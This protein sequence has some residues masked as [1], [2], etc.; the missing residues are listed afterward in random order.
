MLESDTVSFTW[1][2]T[3]LWQEFCPFLQRKCTFARTNENLMRLVLFR[4]SFTMWFMSF[5][6]NEITAKS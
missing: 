1:L 3:S 4:G 2:I 6:R 5:K